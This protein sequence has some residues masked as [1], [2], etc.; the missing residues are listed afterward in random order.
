M[1]AYTNVVLLKGHIRSP[2]KEHFIK[3]EGKEPIKWINFSIAVNDKYHNESNFFNIIAFDK[4]AD[5]I[6]KHSRRNDHVFIR[7]RLT[8]NNQRGVVWTNV[9]VEDF[10]ILKYAP[11]KTTGELT[12]LLDEIAD[13]ME[14]NNMTFE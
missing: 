1:Y 4:I 9:V 13:E 8:Q 7:G 2:F 11:N 14:E 3:K 12:E 10:D 6:Q 5:Y